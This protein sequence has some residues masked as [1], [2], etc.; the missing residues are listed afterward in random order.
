MRI[1]A[2]SASGRR[3]IASSASF[4]AVRRFAEAFFEAAFFGGAGILRQWR[5]PPSPELSEAWCGDG[6]DLSR[7]RGHRA[8]KSPGDSSDVTSG[9]TFGVHVA[10]EVGRDPQ[11]PKLLRHVLKVLELAEE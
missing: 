11:S 3:F 2:S 8:A 1:T 5:G 4:R 6:R 7:Q 10:F 9:A